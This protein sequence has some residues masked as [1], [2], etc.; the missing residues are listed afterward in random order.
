ME[1]TLVT[2]V[3]FCQD[4]RFFVSGI[5]L[6]E[7]F[8]PNLIFSCTGMIDNRSFKKFPFELVSARGHNVYH[9]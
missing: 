1:E 3:S 5:L 7:Y 4:S 6:L 2:N 8:R 9:T